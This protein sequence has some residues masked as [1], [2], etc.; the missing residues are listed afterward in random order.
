MVVL[1]GQGE[2]I[3]E[4]RRVLDAV[5]ERVSRSSEPVIWVWCP[6][7]HVAFGPRNTRHDRYEEAVTVAE[8]HGYPA[9]ER[10]VGG[11]PVAHTGSTLVFLRAVPI[12]NPREGLHE[13]YADTVDR[14][15]RALTDLGVESEQGEPPGAF[16]P[17]DH[18]LSADGKLVGIAQRVTADMA[19]ISGIVVVSDEA[20]IAE[21]L[22][23]IY[24]LLDLEFDPTSV[25]SISSAGGP[26]D[27]ETVIERIQLAL[28]DADHLQTI[29]VERFL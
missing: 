13:R 27:I 22:G 21:V 11:H 28:S 6:E 20:A 8:T 26:A 23:A 2:T 24:P 3:E 5:Y 16:C 9:I 14:L 10:T 19:V 25:G 4:N 1:E 29:P 7:R 12:D 15:Q 17:G 18:S